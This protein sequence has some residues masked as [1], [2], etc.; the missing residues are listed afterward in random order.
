[1]ITKK[2]IIKMAKHVVRRDQHIPDRRLIH[3][4]RDWACIVMIFFLCAG[5]GVLYNAQLFDRFETL[6]MEL[7][8]SDSRAVS[9]N[10]ERLNT[11]VSYYR[12]RKVLFDAMTK[13][14]PVYIP[15][16]VSTSSATSTESTVASDTTD[17]EL[18]SDNEI[19]S[20]E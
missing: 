4:E 1:M 13:D 6:E 18:D 17:L 8:P 12:E 9:Y 19:P 11:A 14:M 3:P 15:P 10:T 7:T 20:I 5:A 2:D 16:A